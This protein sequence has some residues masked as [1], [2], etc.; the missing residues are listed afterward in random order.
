M[1]NKNSFCLFLLFFS[2]CFSSG[3]QVVQDPLKDMVNSK[4]GGSQTYY[5]WVVDI[6]HDGI[7]D[8][9]LSQKLSPEL[10]KA[11]EST[12]GEDY[13]SDLLG[14]TLYIGLKTGGYIKNSGVI[15]DV[16]QCYVGYID[17]TKQYGIVTLEQRRVGDQDVPEAR[18]GV[19]KEQVYCYTVKGD[20]LA[21]TN[22]TPLFDADEKNA[23]FEKYLSDSIRTKVQLQVMTLK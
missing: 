6:N 14:F 10:V 2:L 19:L 7:M 20:H 12:Q 13:Q 11:M 1:K 18:H 3:A 5:K 22:L 8:V 16:S 9:M 15:I 21:R 23:V 17:E 4:K